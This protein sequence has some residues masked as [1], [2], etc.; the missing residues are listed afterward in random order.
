MRPF[1]SVSWLAIF[2]LSAL[3]AVAGAQS[4]IR[5]PDN[6]ATTP[7]GKSRLRT[8]RIVDLTHPFEVSEPCDFVQAR[9]A[10][11]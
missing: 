9:R 11:V 4:Q 8:D 3:V 5:T 6:Q 1:R 10:G 2:G 7:L